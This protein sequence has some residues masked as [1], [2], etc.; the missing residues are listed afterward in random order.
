MITGSRYPIK[1]LRIAVRIDH[2]AVAGRSLRSLETAFRRCGFEV[3][4][5]G[6]HASGATEMS[7]I[8]AADGSYIELIAVADSNRLLD[9]P[10]WND[11]L[12]ADGGP[13]GWAIVVNDLDD[14]IRRL[15][16]AGVNVH[17][18]VAGHRQRP[19]G[20]DVR[21]RMAFL[22][23]TRSSATLSPSGPGATLP[24]LIEDLTPHELRVPPVPDLSD[25]T[26]ARRVQ[27]VAGVILAV[28]NCEQTATRF[29]QLF[30]LSPAYSALDE[31]FGAEL[32]WFSESPV[33][34]AAPL[35]SGDW[36]RRRLEQFGPTPCAYLFATVDW[37]DSYV[38]GGVMRDFCDRRVCWF[39]AERLRGTRIGLVHGKDIEEG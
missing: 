13:C 35:D 8:P 22:G 7:I 31:E 39:D 5:G 21:W 38:S 34:L 9:N 17:G 19:D 10:F 29:Q 18:P 32:V 30:N 15:E 3:I 27:A 26:P 25:A 16:I 23:E 1:H 24:F 6:L 4:S 14:T 2:V 33:I 20:K 37:S 28:E 12:L 11:H 36:L